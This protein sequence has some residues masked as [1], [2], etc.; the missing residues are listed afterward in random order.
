MDLL[1]VLLAL[2]LVGVFAFALDGALTAMRSAHLDLFGV[3]TLGIVTAIGGGLLRDVLLGELPPAS[4][5]TWYY[6]TT[7]TAGALAAFWGHRLLSRLSRPILIFDTAGLS[8]FCITGAQT[9]LES[10]LGG[11][12]AILLG[13]LTAVGGG[14]LRDVLVR[15]VPSILTGGLY[16]VPALVGA[17]VAVLG[18]EFGADTLAWSLLGAAA[19]AALRIGGI[20]RG[21]HAPRAALSSPDALDE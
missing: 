10:G 17:S 8:L 19:C 14:T 21:W 20:L 13:G 7:A 15:R 16:A 3:V 11:G 2:E 5:R 18:D 1:D 12:Q 6:L 9:A 4:L